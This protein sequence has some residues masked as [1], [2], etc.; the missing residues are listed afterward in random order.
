MLFS[1]AGPMAQGNDPQ[2][3]RP[4]APARGIRANVVSPGM[5]Y[6]ESGIWHQFRQG[7]PDLYKQTLARN[8]MGRMA[9]P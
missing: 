9:S 4:C 2:C 7:L 6:F 3:Q 5:V 8:P 1:S